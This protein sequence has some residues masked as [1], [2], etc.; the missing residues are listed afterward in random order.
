MA[1]LDLSKTAAE[2]YANFLQADA[3]IQ[4]GP[5]DATVRELVKLRVSQINGCVFCVDKHSREALE[6]GEDQDRLLQLPV[7]QESELF[8]ERER[9]ALT[10]AE[11]ATRREHITDELW[12]SLRA[13]FPDEAELGHPVA[14]VALINAFNLIAMPLEK[15]PPRR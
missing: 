11:A 8:D 7:W 6:L 10:Y 14:Q 12:D 1:R 13:A 15:R 2:P 4:E 9:A 3:A 5:L